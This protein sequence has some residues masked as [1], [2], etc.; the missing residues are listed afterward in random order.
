M[1]LYQLKSK[2]ISWEKKRV[3][4]GGKRGTT[5]GRGQKGQKSRAGHRIRP[6]VR[7]IINRLPKWRGFHNK[8]KSLKPVSLNLKNLKNLSGIIDIGAL[9]K[10][11]L[12]D[13]KYKGRVKI[14]SGG[15]AKNW[16]IKGL[17]LSEDAKNKI[18]K[19]GGEIQK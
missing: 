9:K 1:E 13:K 15:E 6:A 12:I 4:R 3:G 17:L 7:D 16:Q 5:S 2:S 10:A 8:I 14:L 19:A 11:G 18:E